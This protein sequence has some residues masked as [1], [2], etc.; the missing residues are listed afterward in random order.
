MKVFVTGASGFIGSALCKRLAA[1]GH[2]VVRGVRTPRGAGDVAVDF[3]K[4]LTEEAWL[5]RL[6]GVDAVVNGVG[7]I[8]RLSASIGVYRK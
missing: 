6:A 4:D 8:R 5:P 3:S 7:M 1:D 2:E